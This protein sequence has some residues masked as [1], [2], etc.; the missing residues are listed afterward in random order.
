M[1]PIRLLISRIKNDKIAIVYQIKMTNILTS[2]TSVEQDLFEQN[3]KLLADK[4]KLLEQNK[5]LLDQILVLEDSL[6]KTKLDLSANGANG[7]T[8]KRPR[9]PYTT[10]CGDKSK[11]AALKG[12]IIEAVNKMVGDTTDCAAL[13]GLKSHQM[14]SMGIESGQPKRAPLKKR[15]LCSKGK[16]YQERIAEILT[17]HPE[18]IRTGSITQQIVADLGYKLGTREATSITASVRKQLRNGFERKRWARQ[19]IANSNG[20]CYFANE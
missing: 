18:G 6:E 14:T 15:R 8:G 9:E 3:V 20:Y 4:H 17:Q 1:Q 7:A 19:R 13:E 2:L 10:N 12:F 5:K 16:S 11:Y